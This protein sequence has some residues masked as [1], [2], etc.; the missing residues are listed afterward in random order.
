MNIIGINV[1]MEPTPPITP[2]NTNDL[3]LGFQDT[4][5]LHFNIESNN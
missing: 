1:S 3:T 2:F 5:F 4:F